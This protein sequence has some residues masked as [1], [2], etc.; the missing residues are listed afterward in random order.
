M[1]GNILQI[2]I[3]WKNFLTNLTVCCVRNYC[4]VTYDCLFTLANFFIETHPLFMHVLLSNL[5]CKWYHWR[6]R[7]R[8]WHFSCAQSK[9]V[10]HRIQE[11]KKSEG[12]S[13][14]KWQKMRKLDVLKLHFSFH[15]LKPTTYR[16]ILV[17]KELR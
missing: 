14:L 4:K 9:D 1:D 11:E 16:I 2:L 7:F 12:I 6:L 5:L 15:Y 13:N 8:K 10:F 3:F 17:V